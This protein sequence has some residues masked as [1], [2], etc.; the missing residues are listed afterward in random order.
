MEAG[1]KPVSAALV[2]VD[3]RDVEVLADFQSMN[4]LGYLAVLA[5]RLNPG[6]KAA[7][8]QGNAVLV[9]ARGI[10]NLARRDR[11]VSVDPIASP[12]TVGGGSV[13]D[14]LAVA[15]WRRW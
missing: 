5:R 2:C 1:A 14:L 11:T 15:S 10:N 6:A 13:G 4:P 9:A 12:P 8:S 3:A 7:M